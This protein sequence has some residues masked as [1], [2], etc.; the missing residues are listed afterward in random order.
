MSTPPPSPDL[1]A[2]QW[3][4]ASQSPSLRAHYQT[5][6]EYQ[7]WRSL[8]I[9]HGHLVNKRRAGTPSD[10]ERKRKQRVY[11]KTWR[12]ENKEKDRSQKYNYWKARI[13]R[14]LNLT[15]IS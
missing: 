7:K 2:A 11:L 4:L 15:S 1:V 5:S 14:D 10:E 12:S 8:F 9:K 3:A 6:A 13:L